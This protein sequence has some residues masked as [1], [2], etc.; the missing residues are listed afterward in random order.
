MKKL[1]TFLLSLTMAFGTAALITACGD[2]EESSSQPCTQHVDDDGDEYCDVC[3]ESIIPEVK[4]VTVVFTVKDLEENALAGVTVRFGT[5]KNAVQET[6]GADGKLTVTLKTG[7]YDVS[8]DYDVDALGYYLSNTTEI[9][10][11]ENTAAMNL[12]LENR[13]PNGTLDRP[14]SLSVGENSITLP[15]NTSYYYIVYRAV[16]LFAEIQGK[17]IKV[18]Y[19]Q[20]VYTP[21]AEGEITIPFLG[22]STNDTEILLFE[23]LSATEQTYAIDITSAPG[24][25]GN[26]HTLVL[27]QDLT[28]KALA[29]RESVFYT[30]KA[31]ESGVLTVTV[32][33]ENSDISMT[34]TSNSVNVNTEEVSTIQL[35]LNAGDEVLLDCYVSVDGDQTAS[36]T[37][38]AVFT[39]AADAE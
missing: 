13:T 15:A 5:G 20:T 25:Q 29:N 8:Y 30:Y 14:Y 35:Q 19:N 11:K 23:N 33:S 24:T 28:T 2:K 27:N 36:V 9:K 34:N 3:D 22:A 38:N 1:Y 31:T 10:V 4:E 17:S 21:N 39:A 6:S 18:T 16:D 12:Y 37:F 26:P 32:K 7:S